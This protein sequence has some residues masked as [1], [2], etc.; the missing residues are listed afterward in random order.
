LCAFAPE[1]AGIY[2]PL[3]GE[4][5]FRRVPVQKLPF[6]SGYGVEIGM[7]FD[8]YRT[9]G[10][11]HFVQVDMGTRCHR[12]RPTHELSCMALGIIQTLFRKLERENVLALNVPLRETM[13][14]RGKNGIEHALIREVELPCQEGINMAEEKKI[15]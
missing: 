11:S 2:Q 10:L 7:I 3:S 15:G 9:F 14:F 5:A 8:I 13:L 1:L 4:Y 6:S 12:N